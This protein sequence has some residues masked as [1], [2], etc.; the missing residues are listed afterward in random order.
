MIDE[1]YQGKGYG[2]ETSHRLMLIDVGHISE[3]LYLAAEA[4][5]CS[6]CAIG[7]FLQKEVDKLLGLDGEEQFAVLCSAVGVKPD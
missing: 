4:S 7:A 1:S 5:N 6:N 2:K 3:Q